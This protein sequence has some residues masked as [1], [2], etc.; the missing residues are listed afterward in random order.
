MTLRISRPAALSS[1]AFAMAACYAHAE[2]TDTVVVTATRTPQPLANVI[3]D[4]ITIGPEQIA[5]SGAGS[6]VDLLQRQRGIEIARNGGA[7]TASSVYIRGANSNQNIVLV[8]GVRIGSSTTGAANW[9][10]I[11]LTA[12]DHIEIVYGPLSSLYGAD[13]IGGVIQIFTKKGKGAPEVTAF[14]GYGSD[15]TRE[16]DAT[17]SGATGGEHSF[18]YAISA[19][20]EKSDGFS[21]TRPGLSSYNPDRD[22][23]DKEN[24]SG[25]F[26]LQVAPGYEAGALFLHSKLE[27]QYDNGASAYDVRSKAELESAAVYGKAKFVPNVDTLLQY[28]ESKDKGQNWGSAAA[29]GYSRIDTKQTDITLQNDV[30][31]GADVLQLLYDHRK[32]EVSTNGS[33]ALNRDRTTNS[34]AASYNARR[35]ANLLNASIRRDNAVY[36]SKNTG[37]I[38]YGYDISAQ[39]RA[40]ASYGTS[41]RAPTYNELYYPSYGNVNNKPEQGKNAEVGLRWDDGVNALSASYFHNQLTNLL[42]NTTPCPFGTAG[43]AF[44][45]AYNVNKALLE[46]VTIAGATKVAGIDL[47]ANL[48]LQD[49]KDD[50]S[51]KR[52]QRRARKH[53]NVT[54]DYSI[55]ALKTG[56]ELEFSG[57]RYDDAANKVRL[58]GYGLVNL[59]ATYT[60]TKDWSALVRWNNIGDK[61]YDLARLYATPGSKVFA[62]IRYGYK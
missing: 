24:V 10:A 25:Q 20:K 60:F 18:S 34:W 42:V 38:G 28:S 47:A 62:G 49:P 40:T 50:T 6:I 52:L 57:D 12:I 33:E 3:S 54:A 43:Y 8:D 51:G 32:E 61:Q 19:G 30:R 39:L 13:A 58:G 15:K 22:G 29:S 41:F 46:G 44:G 14:A 55:G 48:D 26:S 21:A 1:L 45:C 35:G 9:S 16:A 53:G 31:I 27:S 2:P 5:A 37:S 56:V 4:T 36:G 23:Y 59:Y 7:G 11:P 17:L